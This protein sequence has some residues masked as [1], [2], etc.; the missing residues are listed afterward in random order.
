MPSVQSIGTSAPSAG[1]IGV[2]VQGSTASTPGDAAP[3]LLRMDPYTPENRTI[4]IYARGSGSVAFTITTSDPYISVTPSQGTLSYPSGTSTIR[5]TVRVNW[6]AVPNGTSTA[7]ISIAPAS[8]AAV[9]LSLPL[10]NARVP[11]DFKGYVE[12]NGAVAM[13]MQHFTSRTPGS[14]GAATVEAIPHYGRTDS[15]L[16][17]LPI[18]AGS[19]TA[20]TA[21]RAVYSF[22]AF[23]AAQKASLTAYLPPSFNVNPSAPLKYAVALDDASPTTVSPVPGSTLGSMPNGWTESV[24][25]GARVVKTD[26]GR[27]EAGRHSVSLWIL[28]PGTVVHRLVVDLGGVMAS[29][30]GPSEST[31]VGY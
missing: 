27:V 20:A 4:D 16:T 11:A 13:E 28:E 19:L 31:K 5:A 1:L 9:K 2:S 17:L 24:V 10:N 26:L 8:G 18:S 3:T 23:S 22:Y 29:Y 30:L 25:N 7:S 12:S 14:S 21:P 15:G 6:G